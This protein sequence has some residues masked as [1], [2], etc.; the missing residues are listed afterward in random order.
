MELSLL[1]ELQNAARQRMHVPISGILPGLWRN[2]IMQLQ[3][4]LRD[5]KE[6]IQLIQTTKIG[7]IKTIIGYY[8]V[9]AFL[10]HLGYW[11]TSVYR[12]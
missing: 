12:T 11:A 1:V 2:V 10:Q 5:G 3:L 7:D 8:Q 4:I 9:V 6:D